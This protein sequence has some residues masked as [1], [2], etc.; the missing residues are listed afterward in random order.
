MTGNVAEW[1][2]EPEGSTVMARHSTPADPAKMYRGGG[3][4]YSTS[5]CVLG[6]RGEESHGHPSLRLSHVGFRIVRDQ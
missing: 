6:A 3:W 4:S 5:Q 1:C 2:W